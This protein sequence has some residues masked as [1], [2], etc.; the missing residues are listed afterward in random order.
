[1]AGFRSIELGPSPSPPWPHFTDLDLTSVVNSS[2]VEIAGSAARLI[3]L[4][5]HIGRR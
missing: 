3:S 5:R 2:V 4:S 1:M